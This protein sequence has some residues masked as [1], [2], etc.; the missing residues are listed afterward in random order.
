MGIGNGIEGVRSRQA[1]EAQVR[2]R[3]VDRMRA[4]GAEEQQV[5]VG[6]RIL[7]RRAG[8]AVGIL[9][10]DAD[11]D[12]DFLLRTALRQLFI[13]AAAQPAAEREECEYQKT[14]F[15]SFGGLRKSRLRPKTE[16]ADK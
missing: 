10:R 14:G 4:A 11:L 7:V 15:H 6:D 16:A 1:L 8:D 3:G 12:R 2:R 13:D 9:G 5:D